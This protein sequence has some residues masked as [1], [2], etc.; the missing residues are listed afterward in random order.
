MLSSPISIF[1]PDLC[2]ECFLPCHTYL[3]RPS[4]SFP[5]PP[6][7]SEPPFIPSSLFNPPEL[8]MWYSCCPQPQ[9]LPRLLPV[10]D[11]SGEAWSLWLLYFHSGN[12]NSSDW[13]FRKLL[14]ELLLLNHWKCGLPKPLPSSTSCLGSPWLPFADSKYTYKP[15]RSVLIAGISLAS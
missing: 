6:P 15:F 9:P 14:S 12:P 10:L 5:P 11:V 4:L 3:E 8:E 13:A 2:F 1:S 7:N